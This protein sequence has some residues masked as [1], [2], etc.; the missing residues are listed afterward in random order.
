MYATPG[1]GYQADVNG[2]LTTSRMD[3]GVYISCLHGAECCFGCSAN[4]ARNLGI[5]EATAT[6]EIENFAENWCGS[7]HI[8]TRAVRLVC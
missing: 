8:G 5:N 4:V 7:H 2:R 3:P 6:R 1:T